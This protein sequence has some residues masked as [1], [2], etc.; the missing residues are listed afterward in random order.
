M[1]DGKRQAPCKLERVSA[2]CSLTGTLVPPN[3]LLASL[4]KNLISQRDMC[5]CGE[6]IHMSMYVRMGDSMCS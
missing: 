4:A 3:L 2:F 6:R 5:A 1:Y